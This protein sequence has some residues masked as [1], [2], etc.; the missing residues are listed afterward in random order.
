MAIKPLPVLKSIKEYCT[1]ACKGGHR[2]QRQECDNFDCFLYDYR[3]GTNPY[4]QPKVL[5]AEQKK[6]AQERLAMARAKRPSAK[7]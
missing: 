2:K 3:N 6:A 4:R 1:S 7:K 5:T